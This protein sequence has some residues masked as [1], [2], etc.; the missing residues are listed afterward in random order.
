VQNIV[1]CPFL[2][3]N[4]LDPILD[5]AIPW[6][7]LVLGIIKA[8]LRCKKVGSELGTNKLNIFQ[9]VVSAVLN[10]HLQIQRFIC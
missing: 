5:K 3:K 6:I 2:K 8:L 10:F 4:S 1:S 9:I 7:Q